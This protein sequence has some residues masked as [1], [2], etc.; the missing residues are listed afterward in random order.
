[1]TYRLLDLSAHQGEIDFARVKKA[2]IWGVMLKATEGTGYLSPSFAPNYRRAQQ[3]GL[4]IGAYH[5]LRAATPEQSLAEAKFFLKCLQG[6]QLDLPLA[7]DVEAPEQRPVADLTDIVQTLCKELERQGYYVVLYSSVSWLKTKMAS[8]AL[9]AF[10]RWIAHV[11]V[12]RPNY[13]KPYGIWQ[14][15]WDSKVDGI[16]GKV[17]ENICYKD[18]PKILRQAKLNHLDTP[19]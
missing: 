9:D 6:K 19:N 3:N 1:M 4:H 13:Q 14:F 8:P 7:L 12:D 10:D 5:F 11:G 2:G 18:Y 17:D 15:T 16:S